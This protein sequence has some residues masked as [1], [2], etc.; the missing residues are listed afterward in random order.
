[1]A[2]TPGKVCQ[3]C[4]PGHHPFAGSIPGHPGLLVSD[5]RTEEGA[6]VELLSP[7]LGG[8]GALASL[9]CEAV[10]LTFLPTAN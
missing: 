4:T 3:A 1:M 2:L 6:R 8:V 5:K 10:P 7:L 9:S